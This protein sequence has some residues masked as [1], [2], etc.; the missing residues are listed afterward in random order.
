M[1]EPFDID[2]GDALQA[3]GRH[4]ERCLDPAGLNVDVSD[5]I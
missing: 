2:L 5:F 3:A 4:V 1:V